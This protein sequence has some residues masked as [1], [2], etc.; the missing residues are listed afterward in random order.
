MD[1]IKIVDVMD[2]D[3]GDLVTDT[4]DLDIETS[5]RANEEY[6]V[7]DLDWMQVLSVE[8]SETAV[9]AVLEDPAGTT[10]NIR[11]YGGTPVWVRTSTN[12]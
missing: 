2:L 9:R 8:K 5:A 11:A 4:P 1:T 10:T 7:E 12:H 6:A 3:Q